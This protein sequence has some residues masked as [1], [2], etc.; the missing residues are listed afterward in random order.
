MVKLTNALYSAREEI[1]K[2]KKT[3]DVPPSQPEIVNMSL[4]LDHA[5]HE[6]LRKYAFDTRESMHA[7]ALEALDAALKA[8]KY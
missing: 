4:R 6:R 2:M 1:L 3:D 7:F 5:L 8:K